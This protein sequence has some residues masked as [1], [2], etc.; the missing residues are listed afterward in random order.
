MSVYQ[1]IFER[2]NGLENI[3]YDYVIGK[4]DLR[5]FQKRFAGY[6]R[7]YG[8]V[9]LIDAAIKIAFEETEKKE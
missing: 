8:S 3:V 4:D 7:K 2:L 6:V 9:R 5:E 1:E